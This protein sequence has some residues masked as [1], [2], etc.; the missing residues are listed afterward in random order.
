VL[1]FLPSALFWAAYEQQGLTIVLWAAGFTNRAVDFG[2]WRGEI[3]VTWVQAF[4]PLL[5]CLLTPP[6]V[7]WWAVRGRRGREP[8]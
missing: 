3:P 8:R 4:D 2:L 5:I 1:L 7:A 6:L